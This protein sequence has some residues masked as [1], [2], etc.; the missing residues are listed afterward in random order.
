MMF[1][2][3]AWI[4]FA[5]ILFSIFI[6]MFL[7]KIGQMFDVFLESLCNLVI[8]ITVPSHSKLCNLS[9]SISLT[10]LRNV[11]VISSLKVS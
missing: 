9:I 10:S 4:W 6:R 8:R 1:W 2:M 5:R 3:C 11:D 7:S